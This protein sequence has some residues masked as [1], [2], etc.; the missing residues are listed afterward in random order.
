MKTTPFW[1][2]VIIGIVIVCALTLLVCMTL[3]A[4]IGTYN[5]WLDG[6][7]LIGSAPC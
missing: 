2:K 7:P 1:L 6:S 4:M 3:T 5:F